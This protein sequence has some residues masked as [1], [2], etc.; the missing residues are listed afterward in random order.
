M[1]RVSVSFASIPP[2]IENREI[3]KFIDSILHQTYPID[4]IYINLSSNYIRF[5]QLEEKELEELKKYSDKIEISFSERDSP[6][7]KYIG[8]LDKIDD[9]T[10]LFIGDDDQEYKNDLIE[11]MV[12]GIFDD[13]YVYQNRYHIVK[14]GTAG[15][16]HGFTGLILKKSLLNNLLK[17]Q[18]PKYLWCDDQ[19]MSIYFHKQGIK[20]YPTIINEFDDIYSVLNS[21]GMEK[22][23]RGG[24]LSLDKNTNNR[25][26]EILKLELKYDVHFHLKNNHKSKGK[27]IDLSKEKRKE[28][29]DNLIFHFVVLDDVTNENKNNFSMLKKLYPT[30]KYY[31]WNIKEFEKLFPNKKL[32]TSTLLNYYTD[33]LGKKKV[34]QL[35]GFYI[36][37]NFGITNRF[38]ILD[39]TLS[40]EK[41]FYNCNILCVYKN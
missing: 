40:N 17:W 20:I 34:Q 23:G 12:K 41:E 8:S 35:G 31:Y 27:V 16:I 21:S 39:Y 25:D 38:D 32:F 13:K 14:T 2:R 5:R 24:D 9:D 36:N 29:L 1:K 7:L 11:N 6:I 37:R 4:K 33:E 26:Q 15:I 30:A 19:F 22:L 3:Y 28:L 10:L 18:I